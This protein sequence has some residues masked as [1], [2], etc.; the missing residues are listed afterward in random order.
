MCHFQTVTRQN[1]SPV[2]PKKTGADFAPV[3]IRV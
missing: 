1:L 3:M 2:H